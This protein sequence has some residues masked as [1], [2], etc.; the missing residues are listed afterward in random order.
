MSVSS[1]NLKQLMFHQKFSLL[2]HPGFYFLHFFHLKHLKGPL[3]SKREDER[4]SRYEMK[5]VV[6]RK[7]IRQE[8]RDDLSNSMK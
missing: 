7:C 5:D 3:E 8:K 6:E 2:L 1:L 4:E